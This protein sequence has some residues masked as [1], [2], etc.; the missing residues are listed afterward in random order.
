MNCEACGHPLND[1]S[2]T[3][4]RVC[5]TRVRRLTLEVCCPEGITIGD[6]AT[7]QLRIRADGPSHEPGA[8]SAWVLVDS[9]SVRRGSR[10]MRLPLAVGGPGIPFEFAICPEAIGSH[11]VSVTVLLNEQSVQ[12]GRFSIHVDRPGPMPEIRVGHVASG[13]A[14]AAG[15]VT[16]NWGTTERTGHLASQF[17]RIDLHPLECRR[18]TAAGTAVRCV[19]SHAYHGK[20]LVAGAIERTG[21]SSRFAVGRSGDLAW[22][23]AATTE[24]LNSKISRRHGVVLIDHVGVQWHS[25]R[26]TNGTR[27]DQIPV[28]EGESRAVA[29]GGVLTLADVVNYSVR[30]ELRE[31]DSHRR[32]RYVLYSR[33]QGSDE[34]L[35]GSARNVCFTAD[36]PNIHNG[37]AVLLT[38][39]ARIGAS[40]SSELQLPSLLDWHANLVCLAGRLWIE[41]AFHGAL[42]RVNGRDIPFEEL[43]PLDRAGTVVELGDD[44]LTIDELTYVSS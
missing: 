28:P 6:T 40:P 20:W 37:R 33:G 36:S 21:S 2:D 13:E 35:P 34:I 18:P 15:N 39:S 26:T 11:E 14:V 43:S 23:V 29:N 4:C 24:E 42:V 12:Q 5:G 8:D 17:R 1:S 38:T 27:V 44:R 32:M 7:V 16:F 10:C 19:L 22:P 41:P 9:N 30:S 25:L 3:F 31:I